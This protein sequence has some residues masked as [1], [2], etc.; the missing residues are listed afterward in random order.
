MESFKERK[1]KWDEGTRRETN[2]EIYELKDRHVK[3]IVRKL[4]HIPTHMST[5]M[6]IKIDIEILDALRIVK[7]HGEIETIFK[8]GEK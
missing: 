4:L 2:S 6:E 8:E 1:K 7:W 5:A 3:H